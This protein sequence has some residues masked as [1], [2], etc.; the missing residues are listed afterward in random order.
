VIKDEKPVKEHKFPS[1]SFHQ[2][3]GTTYS[4]LP[5]IHVPQ[6]FQLKEPK[7]RVPFTSQP[8]FPEFFTHSWSLV[9]VTALSP[10]QLY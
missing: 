7:R 9:P 6:N 8:V 2:E 1:G 5:F 10:R 4:G 3:K